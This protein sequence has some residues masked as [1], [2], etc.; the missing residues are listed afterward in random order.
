[1]HLQTSTCMDNSTGPALP[2]L[3]RFMLHIC[4]QPRHPPSRMMPVP[5]QWTCLGHLAICQANM[6]QLGPLIGHS[7]VVIRTRLH[8]ASGGV[9]RSQTA[10][11][12]R[13]CQAL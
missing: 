12:A 3:R 9:P 8:T 10:A 11:I 1:M 7:R 6:R 5:P 2:H 13:P 4:M